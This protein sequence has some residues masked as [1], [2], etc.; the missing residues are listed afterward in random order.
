MASS[1]EARQEA[2]DER[3]GEF[4]RES[5]RRYEARLAEEAEAR[6]AAR[7][8]TRCGTVIAEDDYLRARSP[9]AA[10]RLCAGCYGR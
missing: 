9:F 4:L 7:T 5:A 1:F 10:E 2:R 8:C 6:L 3:Y